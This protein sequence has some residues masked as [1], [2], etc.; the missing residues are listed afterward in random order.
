MCGE[1]MIVDKGVNEKGTCFKFNTYLKICQPYGGKEY[2]IESCNEPSRLSIPAPEASHVVLFI[3][4]E[5]RLKVTK[6]TMQR[7]GINVSATNSYEL[8]CSTLKYISKKLLICPNITSDKFEDDSTKTDCLSRAVSRNSSTTK[9]KTSSSSSRTVTSN[10]LIVA[11]RS[12]AIFSELGKAVDDFRKELSDICCRV[13][14]IDRPGTDQV[15]QQYKFRQTDQIIYKPFHGSR[16]DQVIRLLPEFGGM[17]AVASVQSLNVASE[18]ST[19]AAHPTPT[20]PTQVKTFSSTNDKPLG[21]KKV[22]LA[23]D[24]M[25]LQKIG[26]AVLSKLGATVQICVNGQEAYEV[27][28]KALSDQRNSE[29]PDVL[30]YDFVFMDCEVNLFIPILFAFVDI[31]FFPTN[32]LMCLVQKYVTKKLYIYV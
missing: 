17:T 4:S 8:F 22:L 28:R 6:S 18:A 23:E 15:H 19:S 32:V 13:V 9:R 10:I 3:E 31:T 14:W 25:V 26:T 2:D 20:I 21:G 27:I 12:S 16:L 24:D 29:P 5:E 11:D 7:R 1:I 30:P